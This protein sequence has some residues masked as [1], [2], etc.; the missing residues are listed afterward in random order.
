[1]MVRL[2]PSGNSTKK[3]IFY[4]DHSTISIVISVSGKVKGEEVNEEQNP[5]W[6]WS[7]EGENGTERKE[8]LSGHFDHR[9]LFRV[10]SAYKT[11]KRNMENNNR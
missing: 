11:G 5:N 4:G 3:V 9:T 8:Q 6:R 7:G 10:S 1:M 2:N